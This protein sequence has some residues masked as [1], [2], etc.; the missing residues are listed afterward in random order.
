MTSLLDFELG[1]GGLRASEES[2]E[3]LPYDDIGALLRATQ[4][5]TA[6]STEKVTERK[7]RP[8]MAVATGGLVLSKKTTREVTTTTTER[9]QVLYMFRRSGAPAWFLRERGAHYAGLGKALQPSSTLNFMTTAQKL[10]ELAPS[11]AY[12]ERLLSARPIRGVADGAAATDI[13]AHLLAKF[14]QSRETHE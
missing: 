7:L 1:S 12:D 13:L 2:S 8:V 5:T 3:T 11:A 4:Q 10:R 14:L 9:Q 6:T